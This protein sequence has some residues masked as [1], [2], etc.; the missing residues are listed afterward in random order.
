MLQDAV[1]ASGKLDTSPWNCIRCFYNTS[2]G[3]NSSH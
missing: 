3:E 1:L 2:L